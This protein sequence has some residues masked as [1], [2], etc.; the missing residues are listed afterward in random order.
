MATFRDQLKRYIPTAIKTSFVSGIRDFLNGP[1]IETAVYAPYRF[2][3]DNAPT[4]RLTLILPSAS[5]REA[6]GG[7]TTGIDFF[8]ELADALKRQGAFDLRIISENPIE[9]AAS[10]F[11]SEPY[12]Q[13][14]DVDLA[15]LNTSERR[16]ATR[17]NEI[18]I[19]FNWWIRLNLE[20]VVEEQARSFARPVLP[21]IYLI[22]EYE[23]AFYPFSSAHMMALRAFNSKAP[24][25]GVFNTEELLEYFKAQGNRCTEYHVFE[26]RMNASIRKHNSNLTIDEKEPLVLVYGRRQIPRNCFSML[27][28]GLKEWAKHYG[29]EHLD[30]RIVSAGLPH[31][32]IVLSGTHKLASLGKLSLDEYGKTLRRTSVGL[33]L[34]SS[35]HPS[36]PPLELAHFGARVVTNDYANKDMKKRHENFHTV[37]DILPETL[38]RALEAAISNCKIDPDSALS[39]R[40]HMPYF[41]KGSKFECIDPLMSSVRKA[42]DL[43]KTSHEM[44][45]L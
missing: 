41:L 2:A 7:V 40:S 22:Q 10:I 11:D 33:C 42:L 15:I 27:I 39:A 3:E 29:E 36:Y 21:V 13:R 32:D 26:P 5:A 43:E 17:K 6:F 28:A 45:N 44:A 1:G 16:I 4:P 19:A 25:L 20:P 34:M 12:S 9:A 37:T 35:P 18:F 23:P 14:T 24:T 31:A 30:W 8:F 38:A